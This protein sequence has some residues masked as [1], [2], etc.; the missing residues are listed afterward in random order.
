[1][2]FRASDDD[3]LWTFVS[4]RTTTVKRKMAAAAVTFVFLIASLVTAGDGQ[5]F[6]S[7]DT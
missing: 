7:Q 1:M 6:P 4:D 5:T 3:A 2:Q